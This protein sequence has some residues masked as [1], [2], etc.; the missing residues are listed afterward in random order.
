MPPSEIPCY[1][2]GYRARMTKVL[3]DLFIKL[4]NTR[5]LDRCLI[6]L[7]IVTN[8]RPPKFQHHEDTF[9]V[10]HNELQRL[11]HATF[12]LTEAL[13]RYGQLQLCI[14]FENSR[15]IIPFE[16]PAEQHTAETNSQPR[17]FTNTLPSTLHLLNKFRP[18]MELYIEQYN[19]LVENGWD[20]LPDSH[21]I[22]LLA[23]IGLTLLDLEDTSP[24]TFNYSLYIKRILQKV[25]PDKVPSDSSAE[26]KELAHELTVRLTV[27]KRHIQLWAADQPAQTA[28]EDSTQDPANQDITP[29][30]PFPTPPPFDSPQSP[31]PSFVPED[32]GPA[33]HFAQNN[34]S[35]SD[36]EPTS[37]PPRS[38]TPTVA[39]EEED[40]PNMSF[41][42][43]D[44]VEISDDDDASDYSNPSSHLEWSTS[45]PVPEH[46]YISDDQEDAHEHPDSLPDVNRPPSDPRPTAEQVQNMPPSDPG[47]STEQ[48]NEQNSSRKI[49]NITPRCRPVV[50]PVLIDLTDLPDPVRQP[51]I[52]DE[53]SQDTEQ[54]RTNATPPTETSNP[55]NR[56][57]SFPDTPATT[58]TN[59]PATRPNPPRQS[60]HRRN[61]QRCPPRCTPRTPPSRSYSLPHSNREH[62]RWREEQYPTSHN[63]THQPQHDRPQQHRHHPYRMDYREDGHYD[64]NRNHQINYRGQYRSDEYD[65]RLETNPYYY[66]SQAFQDRSYNHY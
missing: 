36:Q 34:T 54:L 29:D 52:P 65:S 2:Q 44:I 46:F 37:E 13:H 60:N 14:C 5:G 16:R 3:I 19:A 8:I 22:E 66:Q 9:E 62:R 61:R 56:P 18:K 53:E 4:R 33:N 6:L 30:I 50:S 39:S 1:E 28:D 42:N 20:G 26:V 41:P 15:Q 64:N 23:H 21:K 17:S 31:P 10:I 24:H 49:A 11:G 47:P 55:Q 40:Q 27:I 58:N 32:D 25:H 59:R 43:G 45:D 7:D 57:R 48:D 38:P 63:R 12:Q 35:D 51:N